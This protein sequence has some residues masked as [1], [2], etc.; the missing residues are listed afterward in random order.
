MKTFRI[1]RSNNP[2]TIVEL[3]F[4]DI[5]N[6]LLGREIAMLTGT[7]TIVIRQPKAYATFNLAAPRAD[8]V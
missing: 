6:L 1:L 8:A 3:S 7:N 2:V 4:R 5:L